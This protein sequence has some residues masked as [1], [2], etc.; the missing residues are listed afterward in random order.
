VKEKKRK[1]TA[2]A[3]AAAQDKENV[4]PNVSAVVRAATK[5]ARYVCAVVEER[6][7]V[8]LRLRKCE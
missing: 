4:N 3:E 2:A 5:P 8:R 6:S 7:R 1:R